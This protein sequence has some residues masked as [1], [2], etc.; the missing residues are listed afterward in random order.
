MLIRILRAAIVA[1]VVYL[2]VIL[3]AMLLSA[4]NLP[5]VEVVGEWLDRFAVVLAVL[6][7]VWVFLGGSTGITLP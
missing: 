6:A 1:V 3:L 7:F 4:L 5:V 2:V